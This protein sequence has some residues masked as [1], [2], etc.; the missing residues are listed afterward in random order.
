MLHIGFLSDDYFY[1]AFFK[2][3][4]GDFIRN[5]AMI[6]A[7]L[8]DFPFFRP[9][10]ILSFNIDYLV[11]GDNPV[12]FHLTNIALHSLNC[13]LVYFLLLKLDIGRII[14]V[15][16]SLVFAL[17]PTHSEAVAWISGRF[18][19]L[20]T[21]WILVSLILWTYGRLNDKDRFMAI[22]AAAFFV[23][24]LSKEVAAA[25]FLLFPL[26]DLLLTI[27]TKRERGQGIGFAWPWYVIFAAVIAVVVGFRFWLYGDIGGYLNAHNGI[28]YAINNFQLIFNNLVNNDLAI[29]FTPISR[30][31][32]AG[33][34][35]G[36]KIL[37]ILTGIASAILMIG[38]LIYSIRYARDWY[39]P[40][41]VCIL[42]GLV[43]IIALLLPVIPVEGVKFNLD[44]SRFLYLPAIG[45]AIW[46]G[47][48]FEALVISR[49][50]LFVPV[51]TVFLLILALSGIALAQQNKN[52]IE[53]GKIAGKIND[54]MVEN[55]AELTDGSTI[56]LVNYPW[57][58]K[59]AHCA[60]LN[61]EG[62]IEFLFGIKKVSTQ[63]T[64][65]EPDN[66]PAWWAEIRDKWNTEGVGFV[67][68]SENEE[69]TVLPPIDLKPTLPAIIL[70]SI[71]ENA[72]PV[73]NPG[74]VDVL[75]ENLNQ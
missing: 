74:E 72:S 60:P 30:I 75:P 20:A 40:H 10:A 24:L 3:S 53:A 55:T 39:D 2:Y 5:L 73:S 50:R 9:I 7:G 6:R 27:E 61:Y 23:A 16:S 44:Y 34:P 66:I 31:V 52:W 68:D 64:K 28:N 29:L 36:L 22:S 58:W 57:L 35:L 67:W 69:I 8:A 62:Y 41:L 59:G 63:I 4:F 51:L 25:G 47:T 37:Y 56:F 18:D 71:G 33:W 54:V 48:S 45:L 26:M 14:A 17:F 65:V 46:I 42:T 11:W 19:L 70:P 38:G 13:L 32:W 1:H 49:R 15:A 43:W 12:G 21:T